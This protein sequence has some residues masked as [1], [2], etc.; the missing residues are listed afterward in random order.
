MRSGCSHH[1]LNIFYIL[2][3]MLKIYIYWHKC[4]CYHAGRENK[5][6][7]TEL[8]SL[9]TGRLSFAKNRGP[10]QFGRELFNLCRTDNAVNHQWKAVV[11]NCFLNRV[12]LNTQGRTG[13]VF[14]TIQNIDK[15]T[16]A[17]YCKSKK[18]DG[19]NNFSKKK[20]NSFIV[21]LKG[22]GAGYMVH[23]SVWILF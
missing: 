3:S 2:A 1:R 7:K 21:C 20:S 16:F 17:S 13:Q 4:S 10:S 14:T 9:W 15:Y 5:Q 18:E 11:P 8:L 22:R 23:Q 6:L 19:S 12:S